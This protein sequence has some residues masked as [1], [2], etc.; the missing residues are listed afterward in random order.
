M[1]RQLIK[2]VTMGALLRDIGVMVKRAGGSSRGAGEL[3]AEL[4]AESDGGFPAEVADCVRYQHRSTLQVAKL[5]D[6]H[7]AYIV[8]EAD[9][10]ATGGEC[11]DDGEREDQY[12]RP[13][14]AVFDR[15]G[16]NADGKRGYRLQGLT[17]GE[18]PNYPCLEGEGL[19]RDGRYGELVTVL[20]NHLR[21]KCYDDREPEAIQEILERTASYVPSV[22][23]TEEGGDISLYDRSKMRAAIAACIT[24]YAEARGWTDYRARLLEAEGS[25]FRDEAAFMLVSGDVS[26]DVSG[27]QG[28]IYTITSKGALKSLR[29]RS[30]YLEMLAVVRMLDLLYHTTAFSRNR[31]LFHRVFAPARGRRICVTWCFLICN[32]GRGC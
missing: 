13:L 3:G 2:S 9:C 5:P 7:P 28:F 8:F 30:F 11:G 31:R 18:G 27:I 32:I 1:N 17:D 25:G 10:I 21:A 24:I 19:V 14:W 6:H 26:G 23:T 4:L 12:P 15:L 22:T 29:A 16:P 20:K